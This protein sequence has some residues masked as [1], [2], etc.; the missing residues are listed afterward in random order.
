MKSI[1][2][3]ELG[4]TGVTLPEIPPPELV[5]GA[6]GVPLAEVPP[7]ELTADDCNSQ[8]T[9]TFTESDNA[10]FHSS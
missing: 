10:R 2:G 9:N 8:Q 4:A 6:T 3:C 7:T 1:P 5:E